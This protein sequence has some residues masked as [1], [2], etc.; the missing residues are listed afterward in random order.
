MSLPYVVSEAVWSAKAVTATIEL[1]SDFER[2]A[3][4]II[5][6]ATTGFSGTLDIQGK[7]HEQA[8]FANVPYIRQDQAA[9]QTPSVTQISW[10]TDTSTYRYVVL[11]YWRKLQLVMTRTAGSITCGVAGSSDAK[12]FP[13]IISKVGHTVTGI[14]SG[15]KAVTTAGTAETLVAS[16]TPAKYVQIQA[17]PANTGRVAIG[18]SAVDETAATIKGIILYPGESTPWIPCDDLVDIYVDV[19]VSTQGVTFNYL[20]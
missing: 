10:T 6:I 18:G 15:S 16:T 13:A 19:A 12:L 17:K 7:L 14:Q 8:S 1:K 9:A 5:E 20:T 4:T 2:C 11:G 3:V